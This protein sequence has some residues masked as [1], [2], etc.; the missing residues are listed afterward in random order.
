MKYGV[1]VGTTL[2]RPFRTEAEAR[3]FAAEVKNSLVSAV[4]WVADL[5]YTAGGRFNEVKS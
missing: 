5:T 4:V 1:Y 2:I 3:W